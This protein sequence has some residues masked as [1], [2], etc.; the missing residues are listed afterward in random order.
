MSELPA[1]WRER[2]VRGLMGLAPL[3]EE[4]LDR[5]S[6]IPPAR[7]VA[8][9][10]GQIRARFLGSLRRQ[11]PG[12]AALLGEDFEPLCNAFLRAHPP[13][14]PSLYRLADP[15]PD[16]LIERGAPRDQREALALDLAVGH[17]ARAAPSRA[18]PPLNSKTPMRWA[19]SLR[20]LHLHRPWHDWRRAVVRGEAPALPAPSEL[21]LA[22]YQRAGLPRDQVLRPHEAALLQPFAEPTP[23]VIGLTRGP[24]KISA[25]DTYDTFMRFAE[26]GWLQTAP[27]DMVE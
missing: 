27:E 7:Q 21:W 14:E 15:M 17:A 19:P 22:V 6:T 1:D 26:R 12:L 20:V 13:A 3:H 5:G 9:Y 25:L 24:T 4:L 11:L 23:L 18:L 2:V 16:W 8:I 10:R